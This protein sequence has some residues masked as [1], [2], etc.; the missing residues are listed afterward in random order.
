MGRKAAIY[1]RI[2][3]DKT[4]A[5]LG[6]E[7]QED[8]CRALAGR[9]GWD[10]VEPIYEDNDVSAYSGKPRPGYRALLAALRA[11]DADAVICWHTDRLHRSPVE[12]EE[13]IE[14]C[15]PRDI[16]TQT[17]KA[18]PLD[19]A[20]PSG[21]LMA[22]QL[23]AYA[24]FESEHHSDRAKRQRRQVATS[25]R[26]SGGLRPYGYSADGMTLDE[27]EADHLRWMAAEVLTGTSLRA[28]A[29]KMNTEGAFTSQGR[30][31]T[32]R[33]VALV[34]QR[35]RNAGLSQHQGEI[36]GRAEWPAAMP[37][38][39]WRGVCAVLGDPARS[40]TASRTRKWL[41]SGL[42]RCGWTSPEGVICG[43]PVRSNVAAWGDRRAPSYTCPA[44]H[45]RRNAV[46]L[47]SYI[48]AIVLER[49]A[50]P[51]AAELLAP[52]R[53]GDTAALHAEDAGLRVRLDELARLYAQGVIDVRQLE[54]GSEQIRTQREQITAKLG[55]TSRGSVLTGVADAVDPAKVWEGLDLSRRRAIVEVLL[56]VVI[57]RTKRGGPRRKGETSFDRESVSVT[58]KR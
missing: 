8:D 33:A 4:G 11:G 21:R 3:G 29:R 6:I 2:S 37:E 27:Q 24:R 28:I 5:G 50:R 51:D 13:Y 14:I 38:D 42:A 12:L 31:W 34:L 36:V 10:V 9:L 46:E 1:V 40:T 43:R 45:V 26:W 48:E 49:L 30:P 22:R 56:D 15:Q 47:D 17:V 7:R 41:L 19:L 16:P 58:W 54:A 25:G 39:L 52:D 35:P 55:A 23:G 32:S 20:T 57:L 44:N 18:G 53:T